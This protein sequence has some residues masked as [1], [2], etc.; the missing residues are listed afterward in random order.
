MQ[1]TLIEIQEPNMKTCMQMEY[2]G[3]G[4]CFVA[5]LSEYW[6]NVNNSFNKPIEFQFNSVIQS[7]NPQKCK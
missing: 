1:K 2:I 7:S 4:E 5:Q 3:C 6:E